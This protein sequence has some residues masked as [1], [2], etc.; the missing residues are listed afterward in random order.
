MATLPPPLAP[1]RMCPHSFS[2]DVSG[3]CSQC[4][5]KQL[6]KVAETP[7]R[8][9]PKPREQTICIT[10]EFFKSDRDCI[11]VPVTKV[12]AYL[13]TIKPNE[14]CE[15][16]QPTDREPTRAY[17]RAYIDLDGEL[18]DVTEE[19]FDAKVNAIRQVLLS[20]LGHSH[21]LMESCK[22]KC[23]DGAGG[24]MNKLSWRVTFTK[25]HGDKAQIST[26]VKSKIHPQ[27]KKHLL[28]TIPVVWVPA[29]EK[30][31]KSFKER[32]KGALE[33][34]AS[35]YNTGQRKMRMAYQ[36]KPHQSRPNK[37][38]LGSFLDTLITYIPPESV[39]L[40]KRSATLDVLVDAA[41]ERT[42]IQREL[43][44]E[45]DCEAVASASVVTQTTTSDPYHEPTEDEERTKEVL[46]GVIAKLS[47]FRFDYYPNWIRL[48]FIL[49]NEN[50]SVEEFIEFS[51]RSKH[52]RDSTS[53]KWI[54]DKWA[55]FRRS[56]LNQAT[57]WRWLLEDNPEEYHAMISN[58]KDFWHLISCMSH[59]EVAQFFYN[60]KTD[61]YIWHENCGWYQ[62]GEFNKWELY[63]KVPSMLKADIWNTLKKV[64]KDHIQ[65]LEEPEGDGPE[66]EAEQKQHKGKLKAVWK[67]ITACGT[68]GFVDG[69]IAFLPAMYRDEDLPVKMDEQRDLLAF[70]DKVLDLT[71]M[72]ARPIEPLDYICINTGY[73]FPEVRHSEAKEELLDTIR[74]IF[75]T[76]EAIE[77]HPDTLGAMTSYVLET[78]ASCLNGN[79][80]YERFY[81]WTG[82]GG[83]GKGVV[84]ELVKRCLGQYYHPIPHTI[85][86]KMSDKK[87]SACPPL[88]KAKGKRFLQFSEPEADDR[89]QVGLI[90][91]LTGG[92]E[93]TARDLYKSTV[94]Y[95]PQFGTFGQ[96]NNI[97]KLNRA[98]GGA[99]RR[100]RV[101]PFVHSFVTDPTEPHQKAINLD[102][103]EKIVKNP[104]W[105]DEMMWLLMEA[106]Q[107]LVTRGRFIEH[108]VVLE[109]SREYMEDNNPVGGWLHTNYTTGLDPKDR[110]YW[111]GA[112]DL[113][114]E[115][116]S[117]THHQIGPER[118]KGG[119]ILCDVEQSKASH[120]FTVT[121]TDSKGDSYEETMKAGKYWVGL[122]RKA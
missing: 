54:R 12:E 13:K 26:F 91:E 99:G 53:D 48:G 76:S 19:E 56:R 41:L 16:T 29:G 17:N 108:P 87:D 59:A 43:E 58:R 51:K 42:P 88:A 44:Q 15:R 35:V 73:P 110:R 9:N 62:L 114:M 25:L 11:D 81:I 47:Q 60:M 102:L 63:E 120:D 113:M 1:C 37:I 40:P 30:N 61:S 115:Y 103:K 57:I 78:I 98:D 71:T 75:E 106:Y 49:Y 72:K 3:L 24:L 101:V 77:E 85:V 89:F 90:K 38:L 7:T 55:K 33:I 20:D 27:L 31:K 80:K 14:C 68:S 65:S 111:I 34:D 83:N 93:I 74:S 84:S 121:K 18:I 66:A 28:T 112:R 23:P 122:K 97:P 4:R 2:E 36:S 119:M 6:P 32:P 92:D 10:N 5:D 70:S 79:N 105:R 22:Y 107:R 21:S 45:G 8:P 104:K 50:F 118:F 67:F 82:K 96:T 86:T 69:V 116:Q 117:D 64:A 95:K 39:L 46:R 100:I 94:I 109:A 52:W